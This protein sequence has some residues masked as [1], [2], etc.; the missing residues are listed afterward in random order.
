MQRLMLY[1]LALLLFPVAV[2][3]GN[4]EHK[5]E[6]TIDSGWSFPGIN[7]TSQNCLLCAVPVMSP[8]FSFQ[9]AKSLN[10]SVL[11]GFRV[12]HYINDNMAI[13]GSFAV[14]PDHKL[15]QSS[16]IVC[17]PGQVCPLLAIPD[18]LVQQNV[19]AY[20]YGGNFVYHFLTGQIRPY[21]LAGVGG[22]SFAGNSDSKTNFTWVF[23]GG[24]KF[25][26]TKNVGLRFEFND[27]L[28]PNHFLTDRTQND[29]QIRY[30][31]V[32]GL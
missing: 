3:A 24:A 32:F 1:F 27:H 26:F 17:P 7:E 15:T 9:Q 30:G 20:E 22:I 8:Y 11:V 18:F 19:V 31:F 12:D 4:V 6:L 23:G 25:F 10:S 21:V 16:F 14:A 5:T 13:E 2:L 28:I 29:L